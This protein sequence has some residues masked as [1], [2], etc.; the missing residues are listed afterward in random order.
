MLIFDNLNSTMP[1]II[2]HSSVTSEAIRY[3]LSQ[4]KSL[5]EKFLIY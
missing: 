3:F 4:E 5:K 1:H 2:E